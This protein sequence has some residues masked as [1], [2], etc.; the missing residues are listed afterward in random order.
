MKI[1]SGTTIS[2]QIKEELKNKIINLENE[3]KITP[4]LAIVQVGN[5]LNS[6]VYI[7]N[8]IRLS[9]ELKTKTT[10]I[11]LD[12]N[13]SQERL[14]KEIE[15][16]NNNNNINGILVQL[17]IPKHINE[18]NVLEKIDPLKDVDCFS[19]ENTGKLWTAK[20]DKDLLK[21]CTPAGV[22]E[23]L[24]R[25]K[26]KLSG[27][28]VVIVGRSNIVGKPLAALF[29]L[30]N[31]TVTICHSATKNIKEIC[32][33]GDILVIAIGRAKMINK[34]YIKDGAVVIDVGINTNNEGKV[35]GDVDFEDISTK[36]YA[37]SPV[38]GGVGRMTVMMLLSNLIQL[39]IKQHK[40]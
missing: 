40:K 31:S 27:E 12:E 6:N 23:M 9:E 7:R 8:K 17:P 39:T 25:E 18:E 14:L 5:N 35:C 37:A 33:Q 15:I 16:L 29:L 4:H 20:K 32:K 13:I 36:A 3:L 30:E 22:I 19:L 38:P 24:K 28:H 2:L 26:I 10:L 34:E 11:K 1:I 21:N